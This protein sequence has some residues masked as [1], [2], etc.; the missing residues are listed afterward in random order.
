L[1]RPG[2]ELFRVGSRQINLVPIVRLRA[3]LVN[4]WVAGH[5]T[6]AIEARGKRLELLWVFPAVPITI[7][8][9]KPVF[10]QTS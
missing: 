6:W 7:P 3:G 9:H 1:R 4:N 2:P 8:T 10:R 5:Q